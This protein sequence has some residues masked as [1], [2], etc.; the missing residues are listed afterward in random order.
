MA[1]G[2]KLGEETGRVLANT[3]LSLSVRFVIVEG[4]IVLIAEGKIRNR[5]GEISLCGKIS[6][7]DPDEGV[8]SFGVH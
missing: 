1:S 2:R 8:R 7:N 3:T 5:K 6:Q 4:N